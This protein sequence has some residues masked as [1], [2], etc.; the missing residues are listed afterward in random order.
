[1]APKAPAARLK[2]VIRRLPPG[3]TQAEFKTA[4]GDE[5]KFK[6]GKV[7]WTLY[8]EGKVS[9]DPAKPSRPA[10][11]Y[12]HLTSQEHLGSLSEMVRDRVFTDAKSTTKDAALLGPPS[13][14]FAPYG[15]VPS[16]RIRKDGRQGTIDQDPDFIDFLESLTNPIT[17]PVPAELEADGEG[18]KGEKVTVT[19][20][21][22]YL[23]DKKANKGR[24]TPTIAKNSKH[25]RQESKDGKSSQLADKKPSGRSSKEPMPSTDKR[26]AQAIK[27]EKAARDAV[28][29]LNK[30]AAVPAKVTSPAPANSSPTASGTASTP[31]TPSAEKRRE[32]GSASAV[33]RMLQRD[34][35]LGVGPGGRR[36]PR[37]ESATTAPKATSSNVQSNVNQNSELPSNATST[38]LSTLSPVVASQSSP[39]LGDVKP[40]V[41]NPATVRPPTGPAASRPSPKPSALANVGNSP[42]NQPNVASTKPLP[43]PS[44]ATQAFLKHANPSQGITEPLLE[45]AFAVFGTINKVEIDKKKGF[46]YVDFAD[47]DGLQKAI[48]ASPVKVAQGQVVVLER[49]TGSSL[50]ARNMRAG[51]VMMGNRGGGVPTGPRGGR[52]GSIRG[53]G[54]LARGSP[55]G[56]NPSGTNPATMPA[57]SRNQPDAASNS[58]AIGTVVAPPSEANNTAP[59]SA[60]TSTPNLAIAET[61]PDS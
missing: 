44:T 24:E 59:S 4:L 28:K 27:V 60:P 13:V 40:T 61:L 12:L 35:G 43:A 10:R 30:Q 50:Q 55:A 32:R 53:R 18:K 46:A 7:D 52:G 45:E 37:R 49:K 26:G 11:A 56:M 9:K 57:V 48:K 47:P 42:R 51:P 21:I 2:V 15:R 38:T 19:P 14:E 1:M 39:S 54:G 58:S 6:G 41:S 20:L 25:T 36:G 34:L 5:W 8:K 29:V 17:K 23:R 16:S 33:A 22:Q 3:L 31:S